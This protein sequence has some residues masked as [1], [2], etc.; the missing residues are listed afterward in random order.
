[1]RCF[2]MVLLL[3]VAPLA[4]GQ[5]AGGWT[6]VWSDEFNGAAGAAP[7]PAKWNYDLGGG[8][9]GNAEAETY[10]NSSKNVFRTARATW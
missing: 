4:C 5:T 2:A 9:W 8:G 10:T 3:S 6:L 7:D 1:M